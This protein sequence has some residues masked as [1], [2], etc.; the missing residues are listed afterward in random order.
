MNHSDRKQFTLPCGYTVAQSWAAI[1]RSWLGFK[2][3]KSRGDTGKMAY[4]AAFISKV[5]SQM[6]IGK[7]VFDSGIIDE[8]LVGEFSRSCFN[9]KQAE[10]RI[11]LE[12]ER[13]PDY[14]YIMERARS[15]TIGNSS[16]SAPPRQTIFERTR[17][18][19]IYRPQH[20]KDNLQS[21]IVR[22]IG[23]IEKNFVQKSEIGPVSK[24][25]G[26]NYPSYHKAPTGESQSQENIDSW[27]ANEDAED[28]I[29]EESEMVVLVDDPCDCNPPNAGY[30]SQSPDEDEKWESEE[31]EREDGREVVI[32]VDDPCYYKPH[33]GESHSQSYIQLDD[34]S[35]EN[36]KDA[37]QTS[38]RRSCFYKSNQ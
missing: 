35:E 29:E 7:T 22:Q 27:E 18:S 21:E 11:N 24:T 31:D 25:E 20:K 5:Q 28:E 32:S 1:R 13:I 9:K 17:K 10:T 34:I 37:S 6:G 8:D 30:E 3:A 23:D 12:E 2:I 38:K 33:S 26:E 36:N 16:S 4:Y 15:F 14:D 19:C